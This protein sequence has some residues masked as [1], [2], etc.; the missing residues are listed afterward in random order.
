MIRIEVEA[1]T[2]TII[3]FNTEIKGCKWVYNNYRDVETVDEVVK[4]V[5]AIF[6]SKSFRDVS[7]SFIYDDGTLYGRTISRLYN[8]T[9]GGN[10]T[11]LH[12]YGRG[13][14]ADTQIE[15]DKLTAKIIRNMYL[16]C[17]DKAIENEKLNA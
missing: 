6:A 8:L 15:L 4:Y 11:E 9:A 16:E 12:W 3:D 7:V 2:K 5:K 17:A 13:S 1:H 10:V 14:T